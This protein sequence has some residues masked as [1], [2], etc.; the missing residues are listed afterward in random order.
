M[1]APD[2]ATLAYE[3]HGGSAAGDTS[4]SAPI[5]RAQLRWK[6]HDDGHYLLTWDLAAAGK[7]AWQQSAGVLG[8]M[9]LQPERYSET[10]SGKS[11]VATHFVGSTGQIVFSN[12]SPS[13]KL[14]PGVQDRLSVLMQ[15]GGILAAQLESQTLSPV[16]QIPVANSSQSRVW[17]F[18]VLGLQAA[19][20]AVRAKLGADASKQWLAV[21]HDPSGD[22]GKPWE[23][24]ITVWYDT[25]GF[26]PVRIWTQYPDGQAQDA[27]MMDNT[28]TP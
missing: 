5:G 24:T 20:P 27:Q 14:T 26:L 11:E 3:V 17:Q 6:K 10:G 12:N 7:T 18:R 15:L 16:I 2:S 1:Q 23:P 4:A 19:L 8:A 21:T 28:D 25:K 9:G 13:A 22:G